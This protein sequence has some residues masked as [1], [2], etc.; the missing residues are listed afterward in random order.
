[1]N[2]PIANDVIHFKKTY[3]IV[4]SY[5]GHNCPPNN[6]AYE[7]NHY[8]YSRCRR[9]VIPLHHRPTGDGSGNIREEVPSSLLLKWAKLTPKQRD[10]FI[11]SC[12]FHHD[13]NDMHGW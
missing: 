5:Y 7:L 4:L 12:I 9:T 1:M 3:D 2:P 6:V 13:Y 11:R 8:V 10:V